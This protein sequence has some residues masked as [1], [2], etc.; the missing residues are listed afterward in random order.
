MRQISFILLTSILCISCNT[1]RIVKI[2]EINKSAF[3]YESIDYQCENG[4]N[5]NVQYLNND[6]N[7]IALIN[8]DK[9]VIIFSNV[10]A[11]SGVRYAAQQYIW[12]TKID[13]GILSDEISNTNLVC[14]QQKLKTNK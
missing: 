1:T 7:N 5:L 3:Q 11:G 13:Y 8:L 12:H 14:H 9:N 6:I 2:P 10:V 4:R